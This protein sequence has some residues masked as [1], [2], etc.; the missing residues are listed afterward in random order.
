[1]NKK[2]KLRLD[3]ETL[4]TLTSATLRSVQGGQIGCYEP[5]F[6]TDS[7]LAG[8]CGVTNGCGG[9]SKRAACCN[10]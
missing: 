2:R 9:A 5:T 8:G 7:A 10:D 1:M 3:M 4:R 6:P